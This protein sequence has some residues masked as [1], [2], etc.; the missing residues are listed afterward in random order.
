VL[1]RLAED[2]NLPADMV[3]QFKQ[4]MEDSLRDSTS[5]SGILGNLFMTLIIYPIFAIL[6]ALLGY[7]FFRPKTPTTTPAQ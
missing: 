6:G 7:A 3:D 1:E 4:Q 5:V 2:G